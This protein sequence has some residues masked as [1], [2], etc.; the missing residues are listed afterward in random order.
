MTLNT[1]SSQHHPTSNYN[2]HTPPAG[3]LPDTEPWVTTGAGMRIAVATCK[4]RHSIA[5][6]E[7]IGNTEERSVDSFA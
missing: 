5:M 2:H 7:A 1:S 6:G 4:V 3:D